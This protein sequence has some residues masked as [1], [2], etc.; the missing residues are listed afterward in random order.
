MGKFRASLEIIRPVNAL[1][2]GIGVIV[3]AFA[4][5]FFI[6][7][8]WFDLILCYIIV[9]CVSAGG[10]II[11][12]LTD[13]EIDKVNCPERVLPSGRLSI[14]TARIQFTLY[15]IV[16]LILAIITWNGSV[17]I[18]VVF[19]Q[20]ITIA[21][22]IKLKRLGF[23]GNLCVSLVTAASILLGGALQNHL[24]IAL[25]PTVVA[26]LC[27]LGREITKGIDDYAGDSQAGVKTIAVRYGLKSAAIL[28]VCFLIATL[29][30]AFIPFILGYFNILFRVCL[31]GI[32]IVLIYVIVQ[33]LRY[34]TPE[35]AHSMKTWEKIIM[36]AGLMAFLLG[37]I[38]F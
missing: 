33:L 27:N 37:A 31:L 12:D 7:P 9:F 18:I 36:L 16:S 3:G 13:I 20:I 15:L 2:G 29:I 23:L 6:E 4:S 26:F 10:M 21:Y 5:G 32:G 28:A 30:V 11:N 38:P 35:N 8:N 17:I 24:D 14:Q 25:W 1:M 19:G 34:P 22:S